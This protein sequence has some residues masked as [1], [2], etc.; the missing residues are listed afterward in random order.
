M[1]QLDYYSHTLQ[2][3]LG[4]EKWISIGGSKYDKH[5]YF[6]IN[7]P[8]TSVQFI[9]DDPNFTYETTFDS[10]LSPYTLKLIIAL[11]DNEDDPDEVF[12]D[13][14]YDLLEVINS[15]I[16]GEH[17]SDENFLNVLYDFSRFDGGSYLISTHDI[18][19]FVLKHSDSYAD[20]VADEDVSTEKLFYN[21]LYSAAEYLYFNVTPAI[22][23]RYIDI[24]KEVYNLD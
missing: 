4:R 21:G 10:V 20:I 3:I 15:D 17:P 12:T 22:I 18:T 1:L 13:L 23:Y 24:Y 14:D 8:Y 7:E 2:F 5:G 9:A 19:K 11:T 6:V 16:E